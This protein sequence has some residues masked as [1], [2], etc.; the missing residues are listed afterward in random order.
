MKLNWRNSLKGVRITYITDQN[1]QQRKNK[2][3]KKINRNKNKQ[4]KREKGRKKR[5]IKMTEVI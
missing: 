1:L 4:K 3:K 5:M 2:Q